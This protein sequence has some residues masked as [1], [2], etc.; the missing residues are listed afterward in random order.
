MFTIY[1][2]FNLFTGKLYPLIKNIWS[3]HLFSYLIKWFQG[4]TAFVK[5]SDLTNLVKSYL[6][7]KE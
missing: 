1:N 7:I 4:N 6:N 3:N 2:L 5:I